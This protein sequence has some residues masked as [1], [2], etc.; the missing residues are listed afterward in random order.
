VRFDTQALDRWIER[1]RERLPRSFGE[2]GDE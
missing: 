1:H 2:A